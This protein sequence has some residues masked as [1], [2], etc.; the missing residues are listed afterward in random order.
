MAWQNAPV[1][2]SGPA[3]VVPGFR[4]I[5]IN[6][7]SKFFEVAPQKAQGVVSF[8]FGQGIRDNDIAVLF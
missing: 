6:A 4:I 2:R 5:A 3:V 8:I 1:Y 7:G